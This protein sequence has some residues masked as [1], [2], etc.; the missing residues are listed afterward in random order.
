MW[1]AD[2]FSKGGVETMIST[3]LNPHLTVI[4][5]VC[6][7]RQYKANSENTNVRRYRSVDDSKMRSYQHYRDA[8]N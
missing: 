5:Q 2:R 4:H 1:S 7:R 3:V 6:F 8:K